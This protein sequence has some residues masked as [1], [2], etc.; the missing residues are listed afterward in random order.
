MIPDP[1]P[2]FEFEPSGAMKDRIRRMIDRAIVLGVRDQIVRALQEIVQ[3]VTQSPR[4]W[5]DPVRNFRH[6][7]LT[8][9]RAIHRKFRCV[10]SVHNRVPIV[11][12]NELTPLKGNPLFGGNY[13]TDS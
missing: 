11:F 2:P 6:A 4:S 7:E 10:Y 1:S 12:L 3:F 9:F 13:D 5:G 8:Q